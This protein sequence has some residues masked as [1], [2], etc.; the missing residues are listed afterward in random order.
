M[1]PSILAS[2]L[3]AVILAGFLASK[4]LYGLHSTFLDLRFGPLDTIFTG[5]GVIAVVAN[6]YVLYKSIT[7]S[8]AFEAHVESNATQEPAAEQPEAPGLEAPAQTEA[9]RS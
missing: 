3:V 1:M 6:L 2:Q 8:A 5:V 9:S 7:A 4:V